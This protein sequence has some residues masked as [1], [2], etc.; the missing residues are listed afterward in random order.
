MEG[1]KKAG[2]DSYEVE[3]TDLGMTKVG[4]VWRKTGARQV[5]SPDKWMGCWYSSGSGRYLR[6]KR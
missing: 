3:L 1:V 6:G 5:F 4:E 2:R